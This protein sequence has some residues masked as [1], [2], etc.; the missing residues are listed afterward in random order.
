MNGGQLASEIAYFNSGVKLTFIN[1][2]IIHIASISMISQNFLECTQDSNTEKE[3][4]T[5]CASPLH[6]AVPLGTKAPSKL[7]KKIKNR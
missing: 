2:W 5:M 7:L 6:W 1:L 3:L 4:K